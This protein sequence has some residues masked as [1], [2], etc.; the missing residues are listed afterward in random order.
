MTLSTLII[1]QTMICPAGD[2]MR[3]QMFPYLIPFII[4]VTLLSGC[5]DNSNPIVNRRTV[6]L[7]ENWRIVREPSFT[8]HAVAASPT[9]IVAL[10][11]QAGVRVST[12]GTHWTRVHLASRFQIRWNELTYCNGLFLLY[13]GD[14][15]HST[16]TI[17]ISSDGLNW[18]AGESDFVGPIVAVAG[19]DTMMLAI[20]VQGTVYRSTGGLDWHVIDSTSA[21]NWITNLVWAGTEF[22][23]YVSGDIYTSIS[24]EDWE[25]VPDATP[26]YNIGEIVAGDQK[27]ALVDRYRSLWTSDN[28][29]SWEHAANLPDYYH[30][31]GIAWSKDIGFVATGDPGHIMLSSNGESW[32]LLSFGDSVRFGDV[33]WWKDRFVSANNCL[34]E[35]FD[36][37][38]WQTMRS[39]DQPRG[40]VD[41]AYGAETYLAV[42]ATA[43]LISYDGETWWSVEHVGKFNS[44]TWDGHRFVAV[45]SRETFPG[46]GATLYTSVNGLSWEEE[47]IC[48]DC[49]V[50]AVREAGGKLFALG[51]QLLVSENGGDSWENAK[52]NFSSYE[53]W[54]DIAY[55]D[56]MYVVGGGLG[57]MAYSSNGR[58]WN[59]CSDG[60][61]ENVTA[62]ASYESGFVVAHLAGAITL[63]D[64]GINWRLATQ[65]SGSG[66]MINDITRN[67]EKFIVVGSYNVLIYS[68]DE[69]NWS[70]VYPAVRDGYRS[71]A[72][73]GRQMV[74]IGENGTI[75]VSP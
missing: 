10:E 58:D 63:S 75:L 47:V 8:A 52:G 24:G 41:I 69:V 59:T 57:R 1:E 37:R 36:G 21:P 64:D 71:V 15:S 55:R 23:S 62:V 51:S 34:R 56:H 25:L 45:S 68:R 6:E 7:G 22:L 42:G 33:T 54:R 30:F 29:R 16:G 39:T 66:Y 72:S 18:R 65:F 27:F 50:E 13:G 35:S 32:E 70:N 5:G 40:L 3:C 11:E 14:Y 12:D 9:T 4:A 73:N 20:T 17:L 46:R 26:I 48:E 74:V 38:T 44:V 53:F 2:R 31:Q 43:N 60:N 49:Y 61:S 19:N 28:G 67:K